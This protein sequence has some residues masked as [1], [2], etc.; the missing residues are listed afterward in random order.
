ML[1][2]T[3]TGKKSGTVQSST[4]LNYKVVNK[5]GRISYLARMKKGH[6]EA[7]QISINRNSLER[8]F[9]EAADRTKILFEIKTVWNISYLRF[10]SRLYI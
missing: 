7:S 10:G 3:L 2:L 4:P 9:P 1:F 6:L 8:N 5:K